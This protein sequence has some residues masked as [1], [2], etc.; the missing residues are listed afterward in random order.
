MR[1]CHLSMSGSLLL[2]KVK[3]MELERVGEKKERVNELVNLESLCRDYSSFRLLPFESF[4]RG[5]LMM[6]RWRE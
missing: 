5:V 6:I 3:T 2:S 1:Q 4:R